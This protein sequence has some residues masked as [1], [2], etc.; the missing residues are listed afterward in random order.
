MESSYAYIL[1]RL[2][3]GASMLGHG[4][5]RIP[6]LSIFSTWILSLYSHAILPVV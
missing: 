1:L 3:L 2:A 6:K 4:L 5:V